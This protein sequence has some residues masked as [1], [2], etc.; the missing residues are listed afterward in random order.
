MSVGIGIGR[1]ATFCVFFALIFVGVG[2]PRVED[3]PWKNHHKRLV[4]S[5][6]DELCGLY[7]SC[8]RMVFTGGPERFFGGA[9]PEL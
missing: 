5:V 9:I 3:L 1:N 7:Q 4:W 2:R 8:N 6:V